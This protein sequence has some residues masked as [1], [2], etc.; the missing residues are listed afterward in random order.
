M[1]QL[2]YETTGTT[3]ARLMP[4]LGPQRK[5]KQLTRSHSKKKLFFSVKSL[6]VIKTKTT[7]LIQL[8]TSCLISMHCFCHCNQMDKT[9]TDFQTSALL[10]LSSFWVS[11]AGVAEV[12]ALPFGVEA[13]AL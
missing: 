9:K 11:D 2:L 3:V 4:F 1:F 8:F 12:T 6:Q 7:S 5:N 13:V 10:Y